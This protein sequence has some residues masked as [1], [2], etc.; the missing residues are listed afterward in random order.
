MNRHL[1]G[2]D[3]LSTIEAE[4][5]GLVLDRFHADDA[6]W[7]GCWL[8]DR[9]SREGAP[10]AIEIR[11]VGTCL[12]RVL[13]PGATADNIHWLK[14][15]MN[16]AMRFER[17]SYAVGLKLGRG[18]DLFAKYGLTLADYAPAGGA[19]VIRV[20]QSGVIGAVAV[21]GLSQEQDH[22]WVVDALTALRNRQ[23][24]RRPR[25]A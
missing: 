5:A 13:L 6:W 8:R 3:L 19:A 4:E 22:R 18:E 9:G 11:R 21:S 7:L 23:S 15:K 1:E 2:D 16:V 10:I 24:T 17:S 25:P 20:A 12:F 14:R